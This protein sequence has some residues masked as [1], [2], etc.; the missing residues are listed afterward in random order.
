LP[1]VQQ[2]GQD[3]SLNNTAQWSEVDANGVPNG[4]PLGQSGPFLVQIGTEEILCSSFQAGLVAVFDDDGTVGRA[5]DSTSITAHSPGLAVTLLATSVQSVATGSGGGITEITS[6][7]SSV[8]ITDPTGPVTDLSVAGG[9]GGVGQNLMLS[10]NGVGPF[11]VPVSSLPAGWSGS[12]IAVMLAQ[13]TTGDDLISG[14]SDPNGNP[15]PDGWTFPAIIFVEDVN[16]FDMVA[17]SAWNETNGGITFWNNAGDAVAEINGAGGLLQIITGSS[18]LLGF[19][20]GGNTVTLFVFNGDPNGS[21]AANDIGDLCI[22]TVTPALWQASAADDSHWVQIGTVTA[23]TDSHTATSAFGAVA[24]GTPK[25]NTLGYDVLV[26]VA[27][28]VSAAVGGSLNVGVGPTA[29]PTVDPATPALSAAGLFEITQ[30]VPADYYLSITS[31]GTI[32][33][34]TPITQVSPV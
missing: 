31:T 34:G 24:V 10:Y 13:L 14:L 3:F 20:G 7:D 19:N 16:I 29:T 5:Y 22:D 4:V 2:V 6:D 17:L 26:R 32:T 23:P 18:E 21:I 30:Y 9:G 15:V 25:Q 11:S 8:T 27:I 28:P 12:G 1:N 33:I